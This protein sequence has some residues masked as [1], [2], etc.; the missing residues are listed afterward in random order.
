MSRINTDGNIAA[1]NEYPAEQ[2]RLDA[3]DRWIESE[4][5]RIM[6]D[7]AELLELVRTMDTRISFNEAWAGPR[8][9]K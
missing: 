8:Y 5:E 6:E 1:L 7:D 4:C 9:R 2:D 3:D